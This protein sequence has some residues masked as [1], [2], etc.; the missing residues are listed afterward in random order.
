[1]SAHLLIAVF[2]AVEIVTSDM[3]RSLEYYRQR[4]LDVP[5]I[6]GEGHVYIDIAVGIRLMTDSEAAV[7][8]LRPGCLVSPFHQTLFD[9]RSKDGITRAR[10]NSRGR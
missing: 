2:D 7:R 1:L 10:P 5:N 8:K 3:A 4:G 9:W 6:S